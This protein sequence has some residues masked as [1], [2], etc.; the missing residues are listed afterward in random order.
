MNT[1]TIPKKLT[2]RGELV[3][4]PRKE[5]EELLDTHQWKEELDKDLAKSI[6]QYRKGQAAGPFRSAAQLK[7][8]LER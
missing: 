3:V 6:A 1:L 8:S 2:R 7:K 5:Y 4:I